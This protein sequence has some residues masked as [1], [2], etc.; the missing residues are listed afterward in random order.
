MEGRSRETAPRLLAFLWPAAY[1][2]LFLLPRGLQSGNDFAGLYWK[3]KVAL[4]DALAFE[5]RIPGW[6]PSEAAGYPFL[7]NP[8]AAA[9][10]PLNLPLAVFYRFAGGYSVF[11]H[12]VFTVFGLCIFS[13]G[14]Y[15]WLRE[16]GAAPRAALAATL[17]MGTSLKMTELQRFPNAMHAAAWFPW[18]L[19]GIVWCLTPSTRLRGALTIAAATVCLVTAGYP[20]F[21][22]YAQFL[23]LPYMAAVLWRRTRPALIDGGAG[24]EP[25]GGLGAAAAIVLSAAG[26]LLLCWPYLSAIRNL[27]TLTTDRGGSNLAFATASS[28]GILD[29]LGS[30]FFPPAASA[31][32]WF[33]FGQLPVLLLA[34][35]VA[36]AL[37]PRRLQ[38][39]DRQFALG[40][41]IFL[42]AVTSLT[43]GAGSPT[44]RLLW[45]AWPG[46]TSL[47]VWPRL[48][49]ILVP[50][51]ALLLARAWE[52]FERALDAYGEWTRAERRRLWL[53]A[54][55]ATA[56]LL[57]VHAAFLL[58]GYTHHYW[59]RYIGPSGILRA[60]AFPAYGFALFAI[61]SSGLL[62]LSL[63]RTAK[64]SRRR[65]LAVVIFVAVVCVD[66][67]SVGLSQWAGRRQPSDRLRFQPRLAAAPMRSFGVPR[68]MT[69]DT[70]QLG[71]RYNAGTI[72]NWYFGSYVTF[73]R[74]GAG[75]G[76]G[77]KLDLERCRTSPD[78]A[79]VLGLT[80]GRRVF[81][82]PGLAA[83]TPSAFLEEVRVYEREA[84]VR[85]AVAAYTG[86]TLVVD[87]TT[88]LPGF[89]CVIDNVAPGWQASVNG[90]DVPIEA[91]F[92]TFK[93]VAIAAGTSRV[94]LQYSPFRS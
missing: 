59:Q 17:V 68:S 15:L 63:S 93:A 77:E 90:R 94:D 20:Y 51:L 73:L 91:L 40:G 25:A 76:A 27:M 32:G 82:A 65:R 36:G 74:N 54:A 70:I 41:G 48:N 66:T 29:T 37:D 92:G 19:L 1:L 14:L 71:E 22:Y 3:Y 69:Y 88:R 62:L 64:A 84:E 2:F 53:T 86:D 75:I 60:W 7:A 6:S 13:L 5:H 85:I 9:L 26:S 4:L 8:F 42:L 11:D 30:L 78:L 35:F 50:V 58:T 67:G 21:A 52:A 89:L 49:V 33:Y 56:G 55:A 18:L 24:E 47:R 61:L 31:E 34:L 72:A 46:A 87:V 38:P 43:W 83:R 57:A 45:L 12:Q 79:T 10:Y 39:R 23:V 16:S 44:F 80:E 28:T 81:F